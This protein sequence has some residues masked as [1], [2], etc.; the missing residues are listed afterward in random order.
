M[1]MGTAGAEM[2]RILDMTGVRNGMVGSMGWGPEQL[3]R[4]DDDPPPLY[5]PTLA[6]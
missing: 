4:N 3:G 2:Y 6:C 5:L 1:E